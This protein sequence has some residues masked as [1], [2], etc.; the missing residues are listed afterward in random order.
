MCAL[1]L[2]RSL[3]LTAPSHHELNHQKVRHPKPET[4]HPKHQPLHSLYIVN[5]EPETLKPKD[6]ARIR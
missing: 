6:Y 3:T 5:P 1:P 2:T 4:L